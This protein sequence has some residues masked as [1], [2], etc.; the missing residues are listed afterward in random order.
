VAFDSNY[1]PRLWESAQAAQTWHAR[2]I[3]A[4]SIGLPTLEDETALTGETA[5]PLSPPAGPPSAARARW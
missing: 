4:A 5:P 3:A 2:A 1:R